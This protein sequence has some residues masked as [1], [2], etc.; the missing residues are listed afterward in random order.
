M[1]LAFSSNAFRKDPIEEVVAILAGLGYDGLEIM[2]DVPH[3]WPPD[4]TPER[5]ASLKR[6]LAEHR[7]GISNVNAFM[8][9]AVGDFHRPSWIEEDPALRKQRLDHTIACVRLAKDLGAATISTEPGGPKDGRPAE[10]VL[11]L[12]R[13]TITPALREADAAGI[14]VLVEPEPDCTI[15]TSRQFLEFSRTVPNPSFGLNCDI[16]H[17]YCVGEEPADVVR[18]MKGRVGHVHLEDIAADRKHHHLTPGDGAI[19]Y[20]RLFDAFRETGYDGWITVEL[21]PFQDNPRDTAAR[22]IDFLKP[23]LG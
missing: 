20:G 8:M 22:A 23:Y 17:F 1:K 7:M 15:E 11:P 18:A 2:A 10:A 13:E 21:Y 5:T 16:G 3:A 9:C 6:A 14:K 19:D 4:M 12:F